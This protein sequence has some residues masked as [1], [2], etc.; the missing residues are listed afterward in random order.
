MKPNHLNNHPKIKPIF[1]PNKTKKHPKP[2][3][4][5]NQTMSKNHPKPN[6]FKTIPNAA[7]LYAGSKFNP[8]F[9]SVY[10]SYDI[11]LFYYLRQT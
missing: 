5:P 9:L 4:K 8:K 2:K 1:E 3:K 11:Y 7:L 6:H 10:L